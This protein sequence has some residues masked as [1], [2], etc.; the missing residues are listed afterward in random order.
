V[1]QHFSQAPDMARKPHFGHLRTIGYSPF[2]ELLLDQW[3]AQN[4]LNLTGS[5]SLGTAG[6][7]ILLI[8]YV[9]ASIFQALTCTVKA[10]N[11]FQIK[12]RWTEDIAAARR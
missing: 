10:A 7:A 5:Q 11:G 1:P 4:I 6:L 9:Y 8:L 12:P 2:Y 3:A